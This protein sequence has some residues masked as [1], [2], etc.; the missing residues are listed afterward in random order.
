MAI[1]LDEL[2]EPFHPI[3]P[4]RARAALAEHW[5]IGAGELT[6]LD[7]ERDD[8]F[9]AG[10]VTLKVAH[11]NDAPEL[12][13]MQ[14]AALE[15]VRAADPGIPV[16]RVV[17]TRDG[18]RSALVDGRTARVLTWID[19]DLLIDSPMT[20]AV[21]TEAGRMLGR[22]NRALAT[23]D[24]PG[25]HRRLAWDLPHLP[26]LGEYATNP[27][28]VDVIDRFEA[29]TAPVLERVPHQL[30]HNDGHPGNLLVVG[31]R[32]AGILDFGD[33]VFSARVC[34]LAIALTYL[35]PDGPRPWPD[36]DTFTAGYLGAVPMTGDELAL[37]P[38]LMAARTIM[39]SVIN[40]VLARDAHTDPHGFY[41][42]NDR[43]LLH[44]LEGT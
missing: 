39:R 40:Q 33:A 36:V 8:T 42:R 20:P 15:H 12:I 4:E 23:F 37:L 28:H 13:E 32:L 2:A 5:G 30:I 41:A 11:P 34:D 9:R 21:L 22:L 14:S 17:P 26:E 3:P 1:A 31:D 27:L 35:V 24:H 25:A 38:M 16:Q 44:L 19:G 7:T 10:D 6:R 43:K 18:A 29:E